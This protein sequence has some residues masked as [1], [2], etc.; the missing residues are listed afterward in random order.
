MANPSSL[1]V[2]QMQIQEWLSE[3]KD[4]NTLSLVSAILYL[5]DNNVKD[6]IKSLRN[7]K[8]MEH[9]ALLV[10]LYLKMDR[11]DLALKELK[12]LKTKDEDACLSQLSTAWT[13]L[14][15]GGSKCQEASY[16]YDELIDKYGGSAILLNGLAVS[17]MHQGA[18][19]EAET[20]L[21]EA[22]TKVL[23]PFYI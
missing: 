20:A 9:H 17:K 19:E 15:S 23:A 14:Y 5:H 3:A 18:Y 6:A 1:E 4:N 7:P 21:Q 2:A 22:L 13:N 12:I 8:T 11:L 10:Q 16:I